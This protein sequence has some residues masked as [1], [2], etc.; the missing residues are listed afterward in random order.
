MSN[1]RYVTVW[2]FDHRSQTDLIVNVL[3][4]EGI[5]ARLLNDHL[6]GVDWM[7]ANAFGGVKVEVPES[8]ADTAI[9]IIRDLPLGGANAST[10][11][12]TIDGEDGCM[13]CGANFPE[14]ESACPSC[15]WT[16]ESPEAE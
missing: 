6:V 14:D 15:G 1:D 16:Y 2:T 13:A 3:Q 11:S 9:A 5:T 7:K 4:S 12:T 10:G 8:L